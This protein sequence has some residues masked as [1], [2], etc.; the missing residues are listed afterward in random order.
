VKIR[1]AVCPYALLSD[2]PSVPNV[3]CITTQRRNR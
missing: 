2:V 1:H 3:Y